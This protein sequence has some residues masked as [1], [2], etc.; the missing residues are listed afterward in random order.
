M[1]GM[2]QFSMGDRVQ[3]TEAFPHREL[4]NATGVVIPSPEPGDDDEGFVWVEFDPPAR[5]PHGTSTVA[6]AAN[7]LRPV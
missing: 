3:L 1:G 4:Q 2:K 6:I 7:F 5:T